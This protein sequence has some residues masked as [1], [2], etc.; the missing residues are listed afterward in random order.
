MPSRSRH[1]GFLKPIFGALFFDLWVG[2]FLAIWVMGGLKIHDHLYLRHGADPRRA[3]L[4][5]A[6]LGYVASPILREKSLWIRGALGFAKLLTRAWVR[7]IIFLGIAIFATILA[8]YQ[9][10][11]FRVTLYDVGLFHQIFWCIG[12]G[13]GFHSTVSGSGDFLQDHLAPSIVLLVPFFKLFQESPLFVPVAQ[14]F[15]LFSG[16]A[17]WVF[18]AENVPGVAQEFRQKLA[19]ATLVF[20][21]TFDS[22]WGNLRWGFHEN[23]IAFVGLSWSFALLFG[24]EGSR[25]RED[26]RKWIILL[27]L[28]ISAL[29]KEILLLDVA[30]IL[31]AWAIVQVKLAKKKGEWSDIIFFVV[32]VCIGI[33][34]I[35]G[36]VWF[37]KIP[38][39]T[40]KNYFNRYYLYLGN[41]LKA[42]VF[43][44][45]HSPLKA[46]G[47]VIRHVG[48]VELLK[49]VFT[50][51][52]PW[53]FLPLLVWVSRRRLL[54]PLP[55]IWL[56]SLL[57]SFA[58][59]ALATYPPL[60]GSN[61]HYVLELWPVLAALTI[62]ALSRQRSEKL[63]WVWALLG[64][65][66]WDHDPL[67]D[68]REYRR[69]A[70]VYQEARALI[71]KIPTDAPLVADELAGTWVSS[72]EWLSRWPE[73][74]FL[75]NSCPEYILVR[76]AE[77]G[78]ILE[79][80]VQ[81]VISRCRS[82]S[83]QPQINADLNTPV[84]MW[85][86]A[87]WVLYHSGPK[88]K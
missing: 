69:D 49:Y 56:V 51:F 28:V 54:I 59:A 5:F 17:A 8:V 83:K 20:F 47:L 74:S 64:I 67:A 82:R 57:P 36:F 6:V 19:A 35:G 43:S 14:V 77:R 60:R 16:G 18:L 62:L 52:L 11:A 40:D 63:I 30:L 55:A 1:L 21:L 70:Q 45:L 23:A 34:M 80:G 73:T 76:N 12:R 9:T 81:N 79:M 22:L 85:R 39:I 75:P 65:L 48:G 38:H 87:G 61:F 2:F 78:T 26:I 10:L 88:K 29:S 3:A 50:V 41:D 42:F 66:R 31:F 72:R 46:V 84:P 4:I 25:I 24:G 71:R 68:L 86:E 58:S 37:E 44:F 53:L 7:W 27:L 33:A 13:L 32:T 15:L